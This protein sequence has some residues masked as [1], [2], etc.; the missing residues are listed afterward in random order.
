MF[1]KINMAKKIF[2]LF[3][4]GKGFVCCRRKIGIKW[5]HILLEEATVVGKKVHGKDSIKKPYI[6]L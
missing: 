3:R 1:Q 2:L 6:H 4:E 5:E